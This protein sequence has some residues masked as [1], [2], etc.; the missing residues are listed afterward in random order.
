MKTLSLLLVLRWQC[1]RRRRTREQSSRP[2]HFTGGLPIIHSVLKQNPDS[3]LHP[4]DILAVTSDRLQPG[5]LPR[6]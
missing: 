3:T 2:G 6:R 1:R 5:W 4:P